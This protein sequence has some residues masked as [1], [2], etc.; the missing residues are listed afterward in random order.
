[1]TSNTV[2]VSSASKGLGYI[3]QILHLINEWMQEKGIPSSDQIIFRG[4]TGI[5]DRFQIS[6]GAAI[7]LRRNASKDK[8]S[9]TAA[10]RE[11]FC[12]LKDIMPY[13]PEYKRKEKGDSQCSLF[14]YS[15]YIS[16]HQ[17]L[18]QN[19]KSTDPATYNNISDLEILADLQHY[20]AATCLVDFSRNM[21]T[22]L[23]FACREKSGKI[24]SP[25]DNCQGQ[26]GILYCY[27]TQR[28]IIDENNLTLITPREVNA[29]IS[30]LLARTKKITNFCSDS[31]YTF[32]LWEP[33][34][35]NVRITKQHSVFLFGLS[36]FII[37]EHP[38]HSIIIHD[39]IKADI[40]KALDQIFN[41]NA[42][43]IF[44]DKQGY[45]TFNSKFDKLSFSQEFAEEF[46]EF[47]QHGL[48]DMFGG[49]YTS[50][51]EF[52]NAAESK[53]LANNKCNENGKIKEIKTI[54]GD[55]KFRIPDDKDPQLVLKYAE[56]FLSKAICYKHI[57]YEDSSVTI[58]Y[59]RNSLQEYLKAQVMF[60]MAFEYF[61]D[62]E[63]KK[64]Y[65]KKF[66]RTTNDVIQML[67]KCKD[68]SDCLNEC[69]YII[70]I[71]DKN[72]SIDN[73]IHYSSIFCKLA[74]LELC[75][76]QL[77]TA[78]NKTKEQYVKYFGILCDKLELGKINIIPKTDNFNRFLIS[79]FKYFLSVYLKGL[80]E[81]LQDIPENID[82]KVARNFKKDMNRI[83][84]MDPIKNII[85][86]SAWDFTELKEII[87][88]QSFE[89]N[90]KSD[91]QQILATAISVRD[92]YRVLCLNNNISD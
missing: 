10:P 38:I 55:I 67:Y 65:F 53:L 14:S 5:Y 80:E 43:T 73:D 16:Y 92:Y 69:R 52:F 64:T 70:P 22:S 57:G 72:E 63:K 79:F 59:N 23:W 18:I 82:K 12:E 81:P 6:S 84:K 90:K 15:D 86:Y 44:H 66:L 21:L 19:A 1:M 54:I 89:N 51:L 83:Y 45:A 68:F 35:L 91:L 37:S 77:L 17:H 25:E 2:S 4:L 13:N 62:E 42:N 87:E 50:A 11:E 46:S 29:S 26:Y 58:N 39:N 85:D 8:T 78:S 88:D 32:M 71:I 27:D 74:G 41:I 60:K 56:L 49:Y 7:R 36:K 24:E 48:D 34:H 30:S 28:D 9:H 75:L 47:Y 20:G 31:K 40:I 76:L 3:S 61:A 33:T